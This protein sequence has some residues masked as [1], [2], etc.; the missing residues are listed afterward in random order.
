MRTHVGALIVLLLALAARPGI[1]ASD[2]SGQVML[3]GVPI[4]GATITATRGDAKTTTI[5]DTDGV[6]RFTGL[7]D[8]MWSVKVEMIGFET[9]TFDVTIPPPTEGPA[10]VSELTLLPLEKIVSNIPA[11]QP[12]PPPAT[13]SGSTSGPNAQQARQAAPP[14][15]PGGGFQRAGVNQVASAPAAPANFPEDAPAD[16]TGMGAAAGSADQR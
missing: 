9:L 2:Y 14:A 16:P 10:P 8:G 7:A 15:N 12:P 6:Y 13:A 1:A 3:A 11:P 5:T 4:P